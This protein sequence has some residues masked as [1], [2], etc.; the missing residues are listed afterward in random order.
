[1]FGHTHMP[2]DMQVGSCRLVCNPRGYPDRL[3][4]TYENKDFDSCKIIEIGSPSPAP[5]G[6]VQP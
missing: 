4:D 6:R 3:R 1:M 2:V 5:K